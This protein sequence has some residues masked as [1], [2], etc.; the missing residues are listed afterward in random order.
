M[1]P[2]VAGAS[3]TWK[4]VGEFTDLQKELITYLSQ[5]RTHEEVVKTTLSLGRQYQAMNEG[6]KSV[7][8][9]KMNY[10]Q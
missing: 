6:E 10:L 2:I 3:V 8:L 1:F 9:F 5:E 7:I 4:D